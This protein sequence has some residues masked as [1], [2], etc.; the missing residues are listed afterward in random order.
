MSRKTLIIVA[1]IIILALL[2]AG[3]YFS[4]KKPPSEPIGGTFTGGGQQI[5]DT[6]NEVDTEETNIPLIP[7][8]G[9]NDLNRLYEL[10]KV[11]VAGVG[12]IE[13]LVSRSVSAR[14]IQRGLGHIYETPLATLKESRISNETHT[15]LGEALWGNA[16]KSVVVRY[17]DDQNGG[18]IMTR[19]LNVGGA[20]TS[21]AAETSTSSLN[22]FVVLKEMFLPDFIPFMATAED[23][24][25]NLFYLE[26]SD[27]FAVGSIETFQGSV[28]TS[29]FS[30]I[31][32]EWLP[33]FPN[34]KLVTLASRPSADVPGHLFFLDTKTKA[35]AKI[36]GSI[37]GLTTK[38]SRDG[39]SVLYAETKNNTINL[40]VYGVAKKSTVSLSLKTLPEK[41]AWSIYATSTV[42]C[43][44]PQTLPYA[45]YPDQWY[46]GLV[47]FSDDV[48]KIDTATGVA[49]KVFNTTALDIINPV[50]S[51]DDSY[52]LFMNKITGTPWVYRLADTVE[53]PLSVAPASTSTPSKATRTIPQS[54][55]GTDGVVKIK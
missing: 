27:S 40:Y 44:V 3:L 13:D 23:G 6:P 5:D 51:S 19:I 38:T 21:F 37:N 35:L 20:V 49:E 7:I 52:F 12:F 55:N 2:S 43:A 4:F 28:A 48:W 32:T 54:T 31:F 45:T 14:Y 9:L 53:R 46:Q 41:C 24:T 10:H 16:G 15:R 17:V 8:G 34:K 33:Q 42:Y 25:D 1:V 29:I 39:K 50:L 47:S 11:P 18:A 30:S 26:N 22:S 36:L